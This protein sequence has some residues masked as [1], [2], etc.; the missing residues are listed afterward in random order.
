MCLG[1][2]SFMSNVVSALAC[3]FTSARA[4]A[5]PDFSLMLPLMFPYARF[6]LETPG[7]KQRGHMQNIAPLRDLVREEE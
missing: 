5:D 3:G 2:K 7:Y 4:R 6:I 1:L